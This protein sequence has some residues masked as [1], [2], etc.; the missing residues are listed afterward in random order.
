MQSQP[1][2]FR[3]AA[4]LAGLSPV[5][6]LGLSDTEVEAL[7][8]LL[9]M[10]QCGEESAS[11]AFDH[12]AKSMGEQEQQDLQHIVEEERQH[13]VLLAEISLGLPRT[14]RSA[15]ARKIIRHFYLRQHHDILGAHFA[16]IAALD[17]A[18]CT[19]L[20]AMTSRRSAL[21]RCPAVHERLARIHRDEADH[22][23]LSRTHA[24]KRVTSGFADRLA[25]DCRSDLADLLEDGTGAF[26]VLG[27]DPV[28]LLTQIRQTPRGLFA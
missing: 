2:C 1:I 17:S 21:Y 8:S 25:Q 9:P 27:I 6:P 24:K 3:S 5:L 19:I 26:A 28:R 4:R 12:L 7:A 11:L 22:V 14:P 15:S 10:L 16:R 18:T 20:A 13:E 23:A